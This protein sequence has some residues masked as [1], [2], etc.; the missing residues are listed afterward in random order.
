M[1]SR[2]KDGISVPPV[3]SEARFHGRREVAASNAQ[4]PGAKKG[5]LFLV[6]FKGNLSPK[7]SR[8]KGGIHWAT[9]SLSKQRSAKDEAVEA[10]FV[11]LPGRPT[12][13][14]SPGPPP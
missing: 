3:A 7:N 5:I 4:W 9:G 2:P 6:E 14:G 8:K 13:N 1:P 12:S 11:V 10:A